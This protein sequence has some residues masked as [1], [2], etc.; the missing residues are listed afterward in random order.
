MIIA[1]VGM[2]IAYNVKSKTSVAQSQTRN[3]MIATVEKG[4]IR[5]SISA[6]GQVET[7]NYL[8]ITTSVNGIVEEVYVSEGDEV[9]KGQNIMRIKLNSDGE[10]SL[11][12]AWSSYLSA[13][14][15]VTKAKNDLLAKESAKLQAEEDF[16]AE[17]ERNSYQTH[18]ERLAYKLAE[19]EYKQAVAAYDDQQNTIKQAEA[20]V[21]KAWYAYQAQ[22][23][24]VVAPDSGTIA[25]IL[26]VEG[27]DIS[28]SLSEKTSASVASI[29]KE[30]TPIASLNVNELDI[31]SVK[32]GQK[33]YVSL[34]SVENT[35][36][37]GTVVGID[38][39]GTS[40]SGVAN[41]PVIV[42]FDDDSEQVLPN[43]GVEAEII[44]Q[45]KADILYI[46]TAALQTRNRKTLV[47]TSDNRQVEVTTGISDGQNTEVL[48]GLA[49]GDSVMVEALPTT[50]FTEAQNQT[51]QRRPD[52]GGPGGMIVR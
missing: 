52:F 48:S 11:A 39:I 24:I 26:V 42:K 30:G 32:V 13:Q 10:E 18:D 31:N 4:T 2:G 38:K 25:N 46:P 44:V 50:G 8:P 27:M 29:K 6:S 21:S 23:P 37:I 45:E 47:T 33:V 17:K 34:S 22:S 9:T 5:E 12:Q 19:N 16:Q 20:A 28:N 35:M 3:T 49:E 43:M 40:Q 1:L 51:Q 36:F 14:A 41:Y 7:A 15:G